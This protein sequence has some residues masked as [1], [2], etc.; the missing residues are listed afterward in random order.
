ML[1]LL[2]VDAVPNPANFEKVKTFVEPR[3][4][5]NSIPVLIAA[6]LQDVIAATT[7]ILLVL[8]CGVIEAVRPVVASVVVAL[9]TPVL[10]VPLTTCNT[11]KPPLIKFILAAVKISPATNVAGKAVGVA[12]IISL[13]T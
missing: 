7:T 1:K 10:V 6:T 2:S 3:K 9:A 11:R 13:K 4:K 12:M 8:N 5:A